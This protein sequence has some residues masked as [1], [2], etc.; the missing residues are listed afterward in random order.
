MSEKEKAPSEIAETG[1]APEQVAGAQQATDED[2]DE[3]TGGLN[4]VNRASC[5]T[6][7]GSMNT[8]VSVGTV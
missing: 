3:M 7:S 8:V 6:S 5:S 2:L 1:E 4:L